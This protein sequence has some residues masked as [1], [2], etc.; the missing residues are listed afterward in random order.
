MKGIPQYLTYFLLLI[1]TWSCGEKSETDGLQVQFRA[2]PSDSCVYLET[3]GQKKITCDTLPVQKG[4]VSYQCAWDRDTVDALLFRKPNGRVWLALF[5]SEGNLQVKLGVGKTDVLKGIDQAEVVRQMYYLLLPDSLPKKTERPDSLLATF[6]TYGHTRTG[7]LYAADS[8]WFETDSLLHVCVDSILQGNYEQYT[9]MSNIFGIPPAIT[10]GKEGGYLGV[11]FPTQEKKR[12]HIYPAE[13]VMDTKRALLLVEPPG[14]DSVAKVQYGKDLRTLDSLR[15]VT[16]TLFP[17]L[18]EL[19][20]KKDKKLKQKH[21]Y[22]L[23]DTGKASSIVSELGT[24]HLPLY[25]ALDSLGAV[26]K[27]THLRSEAIN[28]FRPKHHNK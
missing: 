24:T 3:Y 22:L 17:L 26:A 12:K 18:D 28:Y 10:K 1:A 25:I 11:T 6:R 15:V 2:L 20:V 9:T 19:P 8:R 21:Y 5:P 23:D 16:Y 4:Q 13:L 27:R 14:M 7:F